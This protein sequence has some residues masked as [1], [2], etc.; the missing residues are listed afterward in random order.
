VTALRVDNGVLNRALAAATGIDFDRLQRDVSGKAAAGIYR[1]MG[2]EEAA[3]RAN[4][5][6]TGDPLLIR[7]FGTRR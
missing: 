6:A 1:A 7:M 2:R 3:I 5:R 4:P